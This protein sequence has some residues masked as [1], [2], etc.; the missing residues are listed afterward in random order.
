MNDLSADPQSAE[1]IAELR[2]EL[3]AWMDSQGDKGIETEFAANNHKQA[4][5]PKGGRAK[6]RKANN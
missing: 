2:R 1:T 3:Q 4:K 6:K 5:Q